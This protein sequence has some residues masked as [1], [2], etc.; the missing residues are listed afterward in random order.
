MRKGEITMKH[1]ITI[2][3]VLLSLL[4]IDGAVFGQVREVSGTLVASSRNELQGR[5]LDPKIDPDI[6]MFISNWESSIPYNTHGNLTERTIFLPLDEGADPVWPKKPGNV[7]RFVNRFSYAILGE[8]DSTTPTTLNGAQEILY[9]VDGNGT[10]STKSTT[11]DLY[12]GIF[13]LVPADCEFTINNTSDEILKMYL[14]SEP[15]PAGFRP[16]PDILVRDENKMTLRDSGYLQT[17]WS[18]NGKNI[19]NVSDGLAQLEL[20]NFLSADPMTIGQPHSHD[21]KVEEVWTLVS[22]EKNL[23]FLGKEVRWQYPGTA[24]KIPPTG[25]TP[26]S[27]INATGEPIRFFYFARFQDHDPR[28]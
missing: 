23:M 16:N 10:I 22:G 21:S 9:I 19:F 24:Y 12:K 3:T 8:N 1:S 26:H 2:I 20:V 11:A 28:P 6:D 7:L 27:N 14:V 17:H 25:F 4:L 13:V 15:T 18:H 5:P